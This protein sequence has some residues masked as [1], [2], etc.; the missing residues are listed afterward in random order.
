[1][2]LYRVVCGFETEVLAM[3]QQRIRHL[4]QPRK[5]PCARTLNLEKGDRI[6]GGTNRTMILRLISCVLRRFYWQ[7]EAGRQDLPGD[8]SRKW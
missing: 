3:D 8:L 4:A 2:V 7:P 6:L 1:M 5:I